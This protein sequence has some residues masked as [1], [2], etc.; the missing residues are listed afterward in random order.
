MKGS[1]HG[2]RPPG[3]GRGAARAG[4]ASGQGGRGLLGPCAG[5]GTASAAPSR[6]ASAASAHGIPGPGSGGARPAGG[7]LGLGAAGVA[8]GVGGQRRS[9]Q[10]THQVFIFF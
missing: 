7:R 6:A 3:G 2:G 1:A 8:P 9:R 10:R 5:G 4:V